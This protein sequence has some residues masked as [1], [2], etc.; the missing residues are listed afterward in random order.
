MQFITTII[1]N[2]V[3]TNNN[4]GTTFPNKSIVKNLIYCFFS[5]INSNYYM[6]TNGV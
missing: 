2:V 5:F 1:N 6:L 3:K 4:Y